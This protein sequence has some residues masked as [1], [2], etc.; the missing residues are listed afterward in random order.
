MNKATKVEELKFVFVNTREVDTDVDIF[1]TNR[2]NYLING[3]IEGYIVT[4]DVQNE[5]DF[6]IMDYV[7]S[8]V[9]V[10]KIEFKYKL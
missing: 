8:K 5:F 1:F 2:E 4:N 7:K 10:F 3:K 9:N 6:E